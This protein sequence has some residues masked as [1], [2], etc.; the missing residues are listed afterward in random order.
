M[1]PPGDDRD[2]RA[3]SMLYSAFP[4]IGDYGFL[5]DCENQALVAPSGNVEWLCLPRVDSPSVFGAILDRDAGAFRIGPAD[6]KVPAARRYLPGT[7]V[8]ET[9]WGT[10]TGWIVVRDV[11]LMGPWHHCDELSHTHRRA[12]TDYDADHGL[13]R[14]GRCGSGE[15][16]ITLDCEPVLDYGRCPVEWEYTSAGYHE[17]QATGEGSDI[18]LRLT[19]DLRLGFE[20]PR[21]K[22]RVS[23]TVAISSPSAAQK[24][25]CTA[26][27]G[28]RLP[29]CSR[30][31]AAHASSR[32]R[33]SN[34]RSAAARTVASTHMEVIIP[35]NATRP[36]PRPARW[37]ARS[38]P[39]PL[40]TSPSPRDSL[41][42]RM[43][44]PA[45]TKIQ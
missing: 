12:P 23:R 37:L 18:K 39:C 13:L 8:L 1:A 31:G 36:P 28:T 24:A 2:S 42:S 15:V 34:P 6:T 35:Q 17:G 33:A 9:S 25:A 16:E 43:P 45:C 4:P 3:A 22:A 40:H 20:G 44:P 32:R 27:D 21:A 29:R 5:S 7:L 11:L 10:E 41:A 14:T 26:S 38:V 30:S 19:T